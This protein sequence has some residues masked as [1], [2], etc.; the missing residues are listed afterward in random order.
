VEICL[1]VR[2]QRDPE[3]EEAVV[4]LVASVGG[5]RPR[6]LSYTDNQCEPRSFDIAALLAFITLK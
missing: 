1:L 5:N 4:V 3:A 6:N 2:L